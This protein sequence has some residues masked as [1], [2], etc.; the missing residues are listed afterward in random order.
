MHCTEGTDYYADI[1]DIDLEDR[2]KEVKNYL[3]AGGKRIVQLLKGSLFGMQHPEFSDDLGR[4]G[5]SFTGKCY[6]VRRAQTSQFEAVFTEEQEEY[7]VEGTLALE[8][9]AVI[10]DELK[11]T[12][13]R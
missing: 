6:M 12:F 2:R 5:I 11:A 7:K 10:P 4:F 8:R 3:D 1:K 9:N 13:S